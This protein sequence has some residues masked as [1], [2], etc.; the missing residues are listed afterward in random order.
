MKSDYRHPV[1][2]RWQ[3][4]QY[5]QK[6]ASSF[7]QMVKL[8]STAQLLRLIEVRTQ[9]IRVNGGRRRREEQEERERQIYDGTKKVIR[10]SSKGKIGK[11]SK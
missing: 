6:A 8:R 3:Q 2:E 5:E 11:R 10:D 9:E 4:C 1:F 7:S